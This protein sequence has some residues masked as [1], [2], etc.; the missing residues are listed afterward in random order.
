M[1][2]STRPYGR[3]ERAIA[4]AANRV[5][6]VWSYDISFDIRKWNEFVEKARKIAGGLYYWLWAYWGWQST[7]KYMSAQGEDL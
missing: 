7:F 5:G 2:N 6:L 3:S 1:R 4:E